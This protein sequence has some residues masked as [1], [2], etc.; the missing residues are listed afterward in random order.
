MILDIV[1]SSG[2]EVVV[3]YSPVWELCFS[4]HV[5]SQPEH[6]LYREKWARK[7]ETAHPELTRRIRDLSEK[8]FQWTLFIAS[9]AWSSLRQMEPA[10]FFSFLQKQN[11]YQW[12][13]LLA[14]FGTAMDIPERDAVLQTLRDYYDQVFRWEERFLRGYLT[15]ILEEETEKCRKLQ[16]SFPKRR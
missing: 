8:T 2:V 16:K 6:H 9:P 10:D 7:T 15:R 11:I 3:S 12:N 14:C 13:Q 5:L 4:L 1:K